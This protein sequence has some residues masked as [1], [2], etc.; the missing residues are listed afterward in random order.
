MGDWLRHLTVTRLDE[1]G[2][3]QGDWEEI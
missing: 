3:W 1:N 2:W